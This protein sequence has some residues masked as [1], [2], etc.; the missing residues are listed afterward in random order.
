MAFL[1]S[2]IAIEALLARLLN[3]LLEDEAWARERLVP[4]AGKVLELRAALA[5]TL[6]LA[7]TA[8]GRVRPAAAEASPAL[9]LALG[10]QILPALLQGEDH[11]MR[12]I[13]TSGDA[14]LANEVLFLFRHLRWDAEEDFARL[15][16]DVAA[17]RLVSTLRQVGSWNRQAFDRAS[18]N[19]M[20]HALEEDRALA[21]RSAFEVHRGDMVRLRDALERLEQ[22]VERLAE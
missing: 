20:E 16:G 19:V 1:F 12:A 18:A 5:P 10:P 14:R 22:R 21:R 15:V 11:V 4:F 9:V 13:E 3:H 6:R 7:I 8:D 17:H 2:M